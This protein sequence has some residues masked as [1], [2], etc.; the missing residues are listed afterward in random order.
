VREKGIVFTDCTVW[1]GDGSPM[2]TD[3]L[4]LKGERVAAVGPAAL[5]QPISWPRISLNGSTILPGLIDSH[6]HL[7]TAAKKRTQLSLE[8]CSSASDVLQVLKGWADSHGHDAWIVGSGWDDS[9]WKEAGVLSRHVLDSIVPERPVALVRR[10]RHSAVLNSEALKRVDAAE[11]ASSALAPRDETGDL[12]GIVREGLLDEVF[13]HVPRIPRERFLEALSEEQRH[14]WSLGITGVHSV[15]R[16]PSAELLE[17]FSTQNKLGLR[18]YVAGEGSSARDWASLTRQVRV[19]GMKWYADGS[20]GSE[21]AWMLSPNGTTAGLPLMRGADLSAAVAEALQAGLN[22]HVHAIGDGAVHEVLDV[23]EPLLS[24][25]PLRSF[26]IEHVQHISKSDLTRLKHSNLILSVQPCHLLSDQNAMARVPRNPGRLDYA[27][28]SMLQHGA[29]LIF[30][31]DLPIEPANPWRNIGAAMVRCED[32]GAPID[33]NETVDW[34]NVLS[35]YTR[36]PAHVAGWHETG[37]LT[38]GRHA[39]LVIVRHDPSAEPTTEQEVEITMFKG[40]V[41]HSSGSIQFPP[42]WSMP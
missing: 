21:T 5:V 1:L 29:T 14:L 35:A 23:Y 42:E 12:L 15:E 4:A 40:R 34:H 41:V 16:M 19:Q 38:P 27:Y 9:G 33:V 28:H 7:T 8:T 36:L 18:L 22:P 17:E 26:R 32:G 31:T 25:H 13:K 24:H 10:D 30:G 20:L 11:G 3:S 2:P 37:Q 39:D 6:V